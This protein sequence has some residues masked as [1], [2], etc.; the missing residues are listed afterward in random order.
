MQVAGA[1]NFAFGNM[2]GAQFAGF[3]NV[4]GGD[5]KYFQFST[6][7]NVGGSF[8]GLQSAEVFNFTAQTVRGMQFALANICGSLKGAQ[9]G[10]GNVVLTSAKGLQF[11]IFNF[12]NEQNGLQIGILNSAK[13]QNGVPFGLINLSTENG[14]ITWLNYTSNSNIITT[15]L[16]FSANNFFS[17]LDIGWYHWRAKTRNKSGVNGFHYGYNFKIN[18]KFTIAPDLGFIGILQDI[19]NDVTEDVDPATYKFTFAL[20][21]RVIFEYQ[22]FSGMKLISGV[23][24]NRIIDIYEKQS[25]KSWKPSLLAG[26][27]LF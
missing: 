17:I 7:N 26:F 21:S 27:S 12:A 14:D 23:G 8:T 9:Y 5:A 18:K 6:A 19:A 3:F 24:F 10:V 2:L 13:K 22:V 11:G 25:I 1:Y 15:G 20:Q 16:K 4:V